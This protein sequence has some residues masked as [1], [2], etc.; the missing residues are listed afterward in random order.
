MGYGVVRKETQ[1]LEQMFHSPY[2]LRH[3]A[4]RL[5]HLASLGI[6]VRGMSVLEVG[7]GVGDFSHYYMDR[8]CRITI[9]EGRPENLAYLRNRYPGA[10]I[11]ELDLDQ[12]R[13][14]TG[15]PFEVVHCYGVLYHLERPA[16]ALAFMSKQCSR[17]LFL[18]TRVSYGDESALHPVAEERT[19]VTEAVSGHG[20]R[21]TRTWVMEAL[22]QHFEHVYLTV[23]QPNHQ[24][25]PLDWTPGAPQVDSS[26]SIFVASR[27]RIDNPL[28]TTEVPARQH[29]HA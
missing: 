23:T 19:H 24:E 29:P 7:A 25:F 17:Y 22:R 27:E 15:G 13:E 6:P 9:S 20:C 5:E 18:E 26:R 11:R 12:P 16:E 21:P 8:G 2:Y 3:T 14:L 10:D 4:R 1:N 28:L